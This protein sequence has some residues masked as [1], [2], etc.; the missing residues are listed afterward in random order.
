VWVLMD[1][2]FEAGLMSGSP[3][4]S[5]HSGQVVGM[6]IAISLRGSRV[7]IGCH[8]IGSIVRLAESAGAGARLAGYQP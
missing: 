5:Q 3:L 8:P 1:E 2:T 6:A 4:I 7:M